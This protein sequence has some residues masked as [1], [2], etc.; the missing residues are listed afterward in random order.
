MF[1]SY[2]SDPIQP[3][4]A[5]LPPRLLHPSDAYGWIAF[6]TVYGLLFALLAAAPL[7]WVYISPMAVVLICPCLGVAAHRLTILMHDC[8]HRNL[9][10][11]WKLNIAL[12]RVSAALLG[13]TFDEYVYSHWQHHRRYG[14]SDDPQGRDYLGLGEASRASVIWHLLR[15]LMGYNLFKMTSLGADPDMSSDDN[16]RSLARRAGSLGGILV[17]QTVVA[18]VATGMGAIPWLGFLYPFSAATVGLFLSQL[19]GFC[20]HGPDVGAPDEKHVRTHLPN[21]LDRTVFYAL[22]FNYHVEHHLFPL[23]P[24]IHLP[25]VHEII[26]DS[27]H[28]RDSVSKSIAATIRQRLAKC[29]R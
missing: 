19:R 28:T 11:T 16:K 15:P 9:F 18:L 5:P 4:M 7:I 12:G 22:N 25:A 1:D 8:G 10:A 17:A 29:P 13:V 24:S 20:E 6:G 21:A 2:L 23:V 27:T 14:L 3:P 26:R